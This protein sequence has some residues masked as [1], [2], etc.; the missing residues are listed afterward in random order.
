MA[1]IAWKN[2]FSNETGYVKEVSAKDKHF[3]DTKDEKDAKVYA[4]KSSARRAVTQLE[5]YGEGKAKNNV[6]EIIE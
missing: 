2:T 5:S 6:F 3:I 4:S 1:K